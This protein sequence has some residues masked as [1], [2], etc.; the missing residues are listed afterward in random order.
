MSINVTLN[1]ATYLVPDFLVY[2]F[3][4]RMQGRTA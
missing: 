2:A 3:C 4:A 1:G